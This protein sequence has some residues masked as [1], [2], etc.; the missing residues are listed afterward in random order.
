MISDKYLS[1]LKKMFLYTFIPSYITY[2]I[3]FI[4]TFPPGPRWNSKIEIITFLIAGFV[5]I[6]YSIGLNS[7]ISYKLAYNLNKKRAR[8]LSII[9]CLLLPLP[10]LILLDPITLYEFRKFDEFS[11][12][13][14]FLSYASG[15]ICVGLFLEIGHF[16]AIKDGK[17]DWKILKKI[18]LRE[19]ADE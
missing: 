1:F 2:I 13:Y 6:F 5:I 8:K 17:Y 9:C 19:K 7:L 14:L 16:E 15:F 12:V 4:V 11:F 18:Y 10:L 3:L